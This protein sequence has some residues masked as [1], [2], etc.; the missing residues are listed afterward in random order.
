MLHTWFLQCFLWCFAQ[1][2]CLCGHLSYF[3]CIHALELGDCVF[4]DMRDARRT[5]GI[6][7]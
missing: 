7:G 5:I 6:D 2:R 3:T 4:T 1:C